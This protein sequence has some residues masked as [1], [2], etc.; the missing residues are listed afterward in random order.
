M[1]INEF[2]S[3][4]GDTDREGGLDPDP[5]VLGAYILSAVSAAMSALQ[6][7][8]GES[9]R[10]DTRR[11]N[12]NQRNAAILK[13]EAGLHELKDVLA[14]LETIVKDTTLAKID[15]AS[16][17]GLCPL[18]KSA[19]LTLGQLNNLQRITNRLLAKTQ[20]MN[21]A[22]YDLI[23]QIETSQTQEFV[24]AQIAVLQRHVQA[25]QKIES[26]GVSLT[27][28]NEATDVLIRVAEYLRNH[29]IS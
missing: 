11:R 1:T 18:S 13:W 14:D 10:Q 25:L 2:D 21:K 26:L 9:T 6:V 23:R 19:I 4:R 7:W 27:Q 24:T 28:A 12:A 8:V 17:R 15:D 20:Q 3:L 5:F 29:F 16:P 22:G